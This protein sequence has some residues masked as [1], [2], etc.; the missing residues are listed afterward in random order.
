MFDEPFEK[1][2]ATL[3]KRDHSPQELEVITFTSAETGIKHKY[4]HCPACDKMLN[5][6]DNFCRYCGQ[7]IH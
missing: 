6:E 5:S 1:Y 4:V 2:I 7:R 3:I